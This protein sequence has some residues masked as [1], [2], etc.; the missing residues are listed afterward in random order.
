MLFIIVDYSTAENSPTEMK[1]SL[2]QIVKS[3]FLNPLVHQK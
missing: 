3:Y 1:K 2:N